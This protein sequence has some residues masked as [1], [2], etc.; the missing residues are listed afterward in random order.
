MD[1]H[2][3]AGLLWTAA[4]THSEVTRVRVAGTLD[5]L[6]VQ[7]L[8]PRL[9]GLVATGHTRLVL[10]LS[11]LDFCD[12]AGRRCLA[13]VGTRARQAGG[14]VV[15]ERPAGYVQRLFTLLPFEDE[16]TIR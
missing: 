14:N 9:E 16:V 2:G 5:F 8:R 13:G 10:D 6:T 3:S 4:Q 7:E 15:L 11:G 12:I 1:R